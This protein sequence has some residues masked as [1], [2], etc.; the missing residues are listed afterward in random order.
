MNRKK[1]H[2]CLSSQELKLIRFFQKVVPPEEGHLKPHRYLQAFRS[3]IE[4]IGRIFD[5]L[6]LATWPDERSALSWTPTR[7]LLDMITEEKHHVPEY[8]PE[9]KI[10]STFLQLM[11]DTML[12]HDSGFAEAC[13]CCRVMSGLGWVV[14]TYHDQWMPTP[15]LSEL[16]IQCYAPRPGPNELL[17]RELNAARC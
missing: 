9:C 17:W 12:E 13:F 5:Y 15:V 10:K 8:E 14:R 7:H 16:F 11:L 6:G 3:G 4:D 2:K 1:K